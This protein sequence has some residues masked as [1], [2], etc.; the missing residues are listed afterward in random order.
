MPPLSKVSYA[1]SKLIPRLLSLIS[2][3]LLFLGLAKIYFQPCFFPTLSW[4]QMSL[5][6]QLSGSWASEQA[7]VTL[8][9]GCDIW[10][11]MP[12]QVLLPVS[13]GTWAQS[14]QC[15]MFIYSFCSNCDSRNTVSVSQCV[16][17]RLGNERGLL[18]SWAHRGM[19]VGKTRT[20]QRQAEE[21]LGCLCWRGEWLSHCSPAQGLC[22]KCSLYFTFLYIDLIRHAQK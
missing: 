15:W 22:E 12:A 19:A 21:T 20:R 8:R 13:K 10:R 14:W 3:F 1:I 4:F 7:L 16:E 6:L 5:I 11:Q 17:L 18:C 2:T 9:K